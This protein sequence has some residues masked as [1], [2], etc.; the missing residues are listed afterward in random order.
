MKYE[1]VPVDRIKPAKYNPR[2]DLAPGD[3]EYERLKR[4]IERWDLVEPLVWNKRSGNLVGG[5]QRLKILQERGDTKVDVSVVDLGDEDEAALNVALNKIAGEWD[6]LKLADVLAGLDT[7]GFDLTLTGFD[8]D[9]L[10]SA[11][12][13]T[14]PGEIV[15]D[16]VPEPPEEPESKPGEIYQLGP[17]RV[18]CGDATETEAVIGLLDGGVEPEV[19]WT[20]PPYGVS[21][22]GKTKDA[23][24]IQA[25]E[26]GSVQALLVSVFGVLDRF[27]APS[28]RFYIAAPAGP[29]GTAFR[30]AIA[31][32]GWR[33]HQSLVWVKDTM[34]LGHSDY[35]YQ[36]EDILYGWKDGPGRP[37]RGK[38]RGS[39]WYGDHTQTT[40]V[41]V[42]RP[43]RSTEHPT[44]KPVKLITHCLG[45]SS[46]PGDAV[47]DPFLGSG[48]T[49]IAAEQVGR[50]CYGMEIEPRY[51]DVIRQRYA[52]FTASV[53]NG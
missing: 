37:G 7:T 23:L 14:P 34:V 53:P 30:V 19:L 29:Q 42:E 5:H 8:G 15:Q 3:P 48:T 44:M 21:Y 39:R 38:H 12:T 31:D 28:A 27:L 40:V 17:H 16:E 33:F 18:M 6:P 4:S 47:I 24:T 43:K 49:L 13:W 36:H 20:D 35:H 45:N 46:R 22:V 10:K 41:Q 1:R 25:D 51:V 32:I 9:D 26:K 50:V 2:K 11:L 52:N